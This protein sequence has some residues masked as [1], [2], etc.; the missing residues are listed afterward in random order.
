MDACAERTRKRKAVYFAPTHV[1]EKY[2]QSFR[3]Q[4]QVSMVYAQD[5]VFPKSYLLPK[6]SPYK[7]MLQNLIMRMVESGLV[8]QF[9]IQ[10][11]YRFLPAPRSFLTENAE[12]PL[13]I[14]ESTLQFIVLSAGLG[15]ALVALVCEALWNKVKKLR[16]H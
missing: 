3:G 7:D 12:Q 9:E 16:Q 13:Q 15:A 14:T 8:D 2:A 4:V 1:L 6:A 5:I 11:W 10:Y